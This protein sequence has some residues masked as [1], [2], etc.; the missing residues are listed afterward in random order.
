MFFGSILVASQMNPY[1][2]SLSDLLARLPPLASDDA[3]VTFL[4]NVLAQSFVGSVD[5]PL[6]TPSV[7]TPSNLDSIADGFID[8]LASGRHSCS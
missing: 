8:A 2:Q 1:G 7:L 3:L 6:F 5:N 4:A